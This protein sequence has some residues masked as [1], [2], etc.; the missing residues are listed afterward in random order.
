MEKVEEIVKRELTLNIEPRRYLVPEA[1][2]CR[3]K[4]ERQ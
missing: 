4:D 2:G 3:G 1:R